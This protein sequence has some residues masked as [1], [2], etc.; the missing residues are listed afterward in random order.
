MHSC[1]YVHSM[2]SGSQ[3]VI[4]FFAETTVEKLTL[5]PEETLIFGKILTNHG[6]GYDPNSGIFTAPEAGV[7][8]IST[9]VSSNQ[10]LNLELIVDDKSI[11]EITV[12][13]SERIFRQWV[14]DLNEGSTV[15][16]RARYFRVDV[17]GHISFS[18]WRISGGSEVMFPFFT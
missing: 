14:L 5:R 2:F 10:P 12:G 11:A 15:Y 17:L 1:F 13:A 3:G 18:G 4:A 8:V 6:D 9:S 7:F 16:V